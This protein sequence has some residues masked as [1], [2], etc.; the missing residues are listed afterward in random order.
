M[1]IRTA[2]LWLTLL[3]VSSVLLAAVPVVHGVRGGVKP[4]RVAILDS[5]ALPVYVSGILN[6]QWDIAYNWCLGDPLL[7]TVV[8]WSDNIYYGWLDDLDIDVLVLV[9]NVPEEYAND[10]IVSFWRKGGAIVALDS[11]IEF[12]CYA[13]ILPES[14]AGSNGI[15]TFWDYRI[16]KRPIV[17]VKHPIVR[18][19]A[20]GEQFTY[21]GWSSAD[22]AC[23][24]ED[25][26]QNEPEGAYITKVA[27]GEDDSNLMAI[28][29]YDPPDKGRVVHI[30]YD[31]FNNVEHYYPDLPR[32]L[33]NAI[34]WAAGLVPQLTASL[35]ADTVLQGETVMIRANFTDE[36]GY[37]IE[38]ASVYATCGSISVA[39]QQTVLADGNVTYT[40]VLDTTTLQGATEVCV[41]A[42]LSELGY[43]AATLPLEVVGRFCIY[44]Q[45]NTSAPLRGTHVHASI[46]LTDYGGCPVE[47][48]DV[49]LNASG[50]TVAASDLGGG[51]YAADLP[52]NQL[53]GSIDVTVQVSK[54]GF[55]PT[56]QT[57]SLTVVDYLLVHATANTTAP[58]E[59][60]AVRISV[61]VTNATGAPVEDANV[62]IRYGTTQLEAPHAGDGIY[63]A[64]IDTEG[65]EGT[66]PVTVVAEKPGYATQQQVLFISVHKAEVTPSIPSYLPIL[67]ILGVVLGAAGLTVGLILFK[68]RLSSRAETPP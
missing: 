1:V 3:L 49:T 10:E 46:Y 11:S 35:S 51:N 31:L 54:A 25:S 34:R 58:A 45:F 43:A 65:L 44:T 6:N 27:R 50:V 36:R 33:R 2:I 61:F 66:I 28:T 8:L 23:Y 64:E 55:E 57:L 63:V 5:D 41:H 29:A 39:L 20:V 60:E 21:I 12:L 7:D 30:W 37:S 68:R 13:G 24:F 19:Y 18:G 40:G 53:F 38:G 9:D 17:V 15:G 67:A 59:G 48:A 42:S 22:L 16:L 47:G 32:L 52:T 56:A 26:M 14:S 62:Y 4:V